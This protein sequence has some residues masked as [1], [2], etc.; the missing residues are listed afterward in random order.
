MENT[1]QCRNHAPP[2]CA[3]GYLNCIY[4]ANFAVLYNISEKKSPFCRAVG[5]AD[6]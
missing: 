2:F 1:S 3:V 6:G 5:N 4:V